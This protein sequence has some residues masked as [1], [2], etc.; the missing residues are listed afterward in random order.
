[1]PVAINVKP[2]DEQNFLKRNAL[3]SLFAGFY[4]FGGF[5]Y[6]IMQPYIENNGVSLWPFALVAIAIIIVLFT[7]LIKT[8]SSGR[9]VSNDTL[10]CGNFQDEYLNYINAKGY[11]YA[12]NFTGLSLFFVYVLITPFEET[13]LGTAVL[14]ITI[15][16]FLDLTIGVL[17]FSYALPVL[18][19][20][21]GADDE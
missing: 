15:R 5:F 9:K 7:S 6:S 21:K 17:I 18:Y 2:I 1:M 10:Y 4:F 12:A 20:L 13:F 14:S 3:G 8:L 16:E 19:M 11:K